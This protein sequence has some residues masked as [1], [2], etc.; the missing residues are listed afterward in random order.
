MALDWE[1]PVA[2]AASPI[3]DYRVQYGKPA[4]LTWRTYP[5]GTSTDR[6]ATVRLLP[7][8]I[9]YEFRVRAHQLGRMGPRPAPP[10][11]PPPAHRAGG[12]PQPGGHRGDEQVTLTWNPPA[13]DGGSPILD[14]AVQL[15]HRRR[16]LDDLV[17]PAASAA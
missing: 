15:P 16:H 17:D 14:Y 13:D 11:P 7:N 8:G 9:A 6:P 3:T 5:D 10:P 1:A 12:P 4:A 2:T